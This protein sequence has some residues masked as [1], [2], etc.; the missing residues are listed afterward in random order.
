MDVNCHVEPLPKTA[1]AE[2]WQT[3]ASALLSV[4][5]MGCQN[6]A[7]SV[8]NSLIALAFLFSLGFGARLMRTICRS[9]RA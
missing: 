8:R 7:V 4:G 1:T 6:C 9:G 2:E 5:G 3:T